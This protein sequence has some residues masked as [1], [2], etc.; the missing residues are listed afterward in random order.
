MW[1]TDWSKESG[2][3]RSPLITPRCGMPSTSKSRRSTVV[4]RPLHA[5][6]QTGGL[7]GPLDEWDGDFSTAS[8]SLHRGGILASG[9]GG[10]LEHRSCEEGTTLRCRA[11]EVARRVAGYS[12][13]R[14]RCDVRIPKAVEHSFRAGRVEL[15]H[16]SLA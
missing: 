3:P 2:E 14:V 9:L 16:R 10:D 4:N 13:K 5:L 11:I 7:P 1:W 8:V 12:S 6:S 15:E